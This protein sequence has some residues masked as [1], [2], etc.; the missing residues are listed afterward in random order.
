MIK[1][2]FPT[3]LFFLTIGSTVVMADDQTFLK[4]RQ[5]MRDGVESSVVSI[6]E[7][8]LSSS[9]DGNQHYRRIKVGVP[10]YTNKVDC[11]MVNSTW[12]GSPSL[13]C[14]WLEEAEKKLRPAKAKEKKKK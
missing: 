5:Q 4:M 13:S 14:N 10:G 6:E 7:G 12:N 11:I 2:I 3:F 1:Y 9:K 8:V